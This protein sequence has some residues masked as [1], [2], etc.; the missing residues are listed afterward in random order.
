[1][2]RQKQFQAEATVSSIFLHFG[3]TC[4]VKKTPKRKSF[5]T[6]TKFKVNEWDESVGS[7]AFTKTSSFVDIQQDRKDRNK[8]PGLRGGMQHCILW[9]DMMPHL[10]TDIIPSLRSFDMSLVTPW[11]LAKWSSFMWITSIRCPEVAVVLIS[12][13]SWKWPKKH[14]QLCVCV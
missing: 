9:C 13:N 12:I 10:S 4:T 1:M 7:R 2:S 5:V 11:L 6:L 3:V 14:T 8:L